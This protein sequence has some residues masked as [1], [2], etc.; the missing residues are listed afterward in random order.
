MRVVFI[1]APHRDGWRDTGGLAELTAVAGAL[2]E[3]GHDVAVAAFAHWQLGHAHWPVGLRRLSVPVIERPAIEVAP[4]GLHH[5]R[6]AYDGLCVAQWLAGQ[7]FDL[8]VVPEAGGLGA[9]QAMAAA[10]LPAAG[11]PK[12][13][14]WATGGVQSKI[15][16]DRRPAQLSDLVADALERAMLAAADCVIVAQGTREVPLAG[17]LRLPAPVLCGAPERP[18]RR[19]DE[20]TDITFVGAVEE[21]AG[22]LRFMDAIERLQA[23][24]TLAGRSITFLGPMR[25]KGPGLS[26][27]TVA[28][29]ARNWTFAL[30]LETDLAARDAVAR[31]AEPHRLSVF[32]GAETRFP[33][34]FAAAVAAGAAVLAPHSSATDTL[35]EAG[36][37]AA[38]LYGSRPDSLVDCLE[39]ALAAPATVA[40]RLARPGSEAISRWV[41]ALEGLAPSGTAPGTAPGT[42]PRSGRRRRTVPDVSVCVIHRGRPELLQRALASIDAVDDAGEVEIILVDDANDV[43]RAEAL[44]AGLA[45]RKDG[46]PLKII[47]NKR[48]LFP[49]A[50]RN[51]AAAAA[52]G[53]CLVFLDGDNWLLAGGL[54]R[55]A[56]AATRGCYDVVT[57][58]LEVEQPGAEPGRPPL[59]MAFL[60]DAGVAGLIFN[61]FGDASLAVRK[62]AFERVGGFVDEGVLG[63]VED[64]VFLARCRA[65][66]LRIGTLWQP[67]FGYY[68]PVDIAATSWR[69]NHKEGALARVRQAYGELGGEDLALALAYMHGLDLARR[70]ES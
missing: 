17:L 40:P 59:R 2:A 58:A 70:A 35:V 47:R 34:L 4:G 16:D 7:G 27:E 62:D 65:C 6:P 30:A 29:R 22:V 68:K 14:V 33:G 44:L 13:A 25:E 37:H 19:G 51:Q 15:L 54:A 43:P 55:L 60:G 18:R 45:S 11:G 66:G 39:N 64:W 23:Q 48:S 41:E 53:N 56:A 67:C 28:I 38:S 49:A 1:D 31:M 46:K 9:Y 10:A 36:G 8:A 69:K 20:F 42:P 26:R 63:P 52:S 24:G 57:S 12:L 50:A 61:G 5:G 3:R 32:A 21:G